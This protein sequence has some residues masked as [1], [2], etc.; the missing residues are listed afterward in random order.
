[1]DGGKARPLTTSLYRFVWRSSRGAQAAVLA[2]GLA[3]PPLAVLP[4]E[5]QKRIVDEAIP[6]GDARLLIALALGYLAA[7]G[8]SAALKFLIYVLRG[9]IEARVA[10]ILRRTALDMQRRRGIAEAR[11][12]LGPVSAVLAE[13]AEPIGG[14]AAEAI[15]T[16]VIEGASL[17][18]VAGFMLATEP[19]LAA[20]GLGAMMLQGVVVPLVQRWIN[21]LSRRRVVAVRR[22]NADLIAATERQPGAHFRD[23]LAELRLVYKLRLRMNLYKAAIKAFLKLSENLAVILVLALGGAMAMRGDTTLGVI[24]AFLT[25]LRRIRDPWEA[26]LSFYRD[27]ADAGVKYRLILG[28]LGRGAVAETAP[29]ARA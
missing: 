18:G 2:L 15:N 25:G 8:A 7:S 9:C 12:A 22:A 10:R 14:F 28:A 27:F 17:L 3:L 29:P 23:A 6:S 1:M 21:R 16:P 4:L 11:L 19:W 13:E 24:V 26:L 20:I 5:L